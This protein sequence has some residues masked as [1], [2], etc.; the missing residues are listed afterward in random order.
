MAY[1]AIL[2][3]PLCK[4]SNN[5]P[6]FTDYPYVTNKDRRAGPI[7][8]DEVFYVKYILKPQPLS[9]GKYVITLS[10]GN[11]FK[12]CK[13]IVTHIGRNFPCSQLPTSTPTG[14][15]NTVWGFAGTD[16]AENTDVVVSFA[17]STYYTNLRIQIKY[18]ILAYIHVFFFFQSLTNWG[19][20]EVVT[21][22]IADDNSI[23]MVAFYTYVGKDRLQKILL[24]VF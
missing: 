16:F 22:L 3:F 21:D 4:G 7:T 2:N 17:V 10:P 12:V 6:F 13:L 23:Q 1:Q 19:R 9:S 14:Q 8:S 5:V 20:E 18:R 11:N 15:E 24:I